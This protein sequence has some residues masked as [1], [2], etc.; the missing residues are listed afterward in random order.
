[1]YEHGGYQLPIRAVDDEKVYLTPVD[2]DAARREEHIATD[3]GTY[4]VEGYV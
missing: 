1:M 2:D 4:D 3:Y